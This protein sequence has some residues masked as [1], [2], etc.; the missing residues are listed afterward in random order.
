M[1]HRRVCVEYPQPSHIGN[2]LTKPIT[3]ADAKQAKTT[4]DPLTNV[5]DSEPLPEP[6]PLGYFT[7]ST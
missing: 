3:P 4:N 1:K 5:R 6:P 7:E 2:E